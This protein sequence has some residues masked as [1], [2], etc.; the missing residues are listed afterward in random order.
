M[1]YHRTSRSTGCPYCS[2]NIVIPGKQI[3]MP[4]S[5]RLP[6]NS[7]LTKMKELLLEK[8]AQNLAGKFGGDV[9]KGIV[10]RHL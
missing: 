6:V 7:M 2:G 3:F 10:G 8:Y 1:V 4:C 5:L 9:I